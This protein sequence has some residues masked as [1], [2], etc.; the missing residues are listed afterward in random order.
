MKYQNSKNELTKKY[1]NIRTISARN[2]KT[3]TTVLDSK[4]GFSKTI[5]TIKTISVRNIK[6]VRKVLVRNI[7]TVR[8]VSGRNIKTLRGITLLSSRST[9]C[10]PIFSSLEISMLLDI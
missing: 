9:C 4:N 1:Q 3:V 10:H 6:T 7:K 2:I 5:K 8:T